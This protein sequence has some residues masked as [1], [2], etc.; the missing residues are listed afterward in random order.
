MTHGSAYGWGGLS[1]DTSE[2]SSRTISA[3]RTGFGI[4]GGVAL[5]IGL[6][7]LFWPQATLSVIAFFFGLY[8]LISG[9][10][11]VVSGITAP[12]SSGL[13]VLNIILGVLLFILGIAAIRN[14]LSS[15]EVLGMVVG[16][17]WIIE[18]IMALTE[19]ETGG[20]RW[21]AI[22]FG[23][24]SIIAGVVVLFLPVE[25]LAALVIFGGIFL[26]VLGIVQLVRAITFGRGSVRAA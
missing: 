5:V 6:L 22:T 13:R 17:A 15:L 8:F 23:V 20:S 4:A 9:I 7:I 16:I 24:L 25:S 1:L 14:P 11:R 19:I 21:Y 12:M 26:V 10:V 2:L 3:V 18:G